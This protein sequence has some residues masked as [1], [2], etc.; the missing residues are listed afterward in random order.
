MKKKAPLPQGAGF[1]SADAGTDNN[2]ACPQPT[3]T[4]ASERTRAM[5]SQR[6]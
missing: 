5:A 1:G 2:G 3:A 4:K 6:E